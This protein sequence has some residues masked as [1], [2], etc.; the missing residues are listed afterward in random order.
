MQSVKQGELKN[1]FLSLRYDSTWYWTQSP[2]PLTNTQPTLFFKFKKIRQ[3]PKCK[4]FFVFFLKRTSHTDWIGWLG[5]RVFD[6]VRFTSP[7]CMFLCG[8]STLVLYYVPPLP[9]PHLPLHPD[10]IFFQ[11][12]LRPKDN[13]NDEII[14]LAIK[15]FKL[16]GRS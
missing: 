4:V 15:L 8:D 5:G 14:W 2:G 12:F 11:T 3:T 1:H 16:Q 7:I 13:Y 9:H 10:L 6:G